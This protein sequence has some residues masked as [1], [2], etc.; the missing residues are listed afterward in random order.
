VHAQ[1]LRVPATADQAHYSV[2]DSPECRRFAKRIHLAGVLHSANICGRTRWNRVVAS[3]LQEIRAVQRRGS[4]AHTDLTNAWL[5]RRPL[6]DAQDFR[7]P[8][9]GDHDS[10]HE[11]RKLPRSNEKGRPAIRTAFPIIIDAF[12]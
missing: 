3:A 9:F 11:M 6:L 1:V 7:A 2:T 8:S 4:D 10:F 5:G 12:I